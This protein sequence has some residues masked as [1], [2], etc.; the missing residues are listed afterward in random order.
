M[1]NTEICI[2]TFICIL[3]F[4]L[5]VIIV[6]VQLILVWKRRDRNYYLKFLFLIV[7]GLIYNVIEGILPDKDFRINIISQNIFAWL[8]GL[9]VAVHYFIYI[10]S[11]YDLIFFKRVSLSGIGMFATLAL[12]FLFILPYTITGSLKTSR[13][14][15]LSF[16]LA[17]SMVAIIIIIKQQTKKARAQ[18]KIIFKIHDFMGI[19]SFLGLI[20]LPF[21]ILLFGDNQFIEQTFFSIGFFIIAVDYFLYSFRKKEIKK[22]IPF[23]K[24][25]I[26]E[27]EI[28]KLLLEDPNLKYSEISKMLNISEKTL[29]THLSNIYKKIEIKSKKEIHELSKIYKNTI[30]D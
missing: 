20:T 16:I 10:K 22:I 23:E 8:I 1:F 28:L 30:T 7:S 4:I 26:R 18:N 19:L 5:L 24:L 3:I 29:S 13:T 9:G 21:T 27:T 6:S 11:E 2:S 17:I 15:F 25:S 14:Y 12:I